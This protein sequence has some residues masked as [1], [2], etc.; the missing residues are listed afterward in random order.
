MAVRETA[1]IDQ[2]TGKATEWSSAE[3]KQTNQ[4]NNVPPTVEAPQTV[5]F[6][7][8]N[9]KRRQFLAQLAAG[10]GLG[11]VG[12]LAGTQ[13]D[14]R[15]SKTETAALQAPESPVPSTP[16]TER[17][18]EDRTKRLIFPSS[19]SEIIKIEGIAP[20]RVGA[21]N[22]ER[23]EVTIL[24]PEQ[25]GNITIETPVISGEPAT[26]KTDL[27]L[28]PSLLEKYHVT[29]D[30]VSSDIRD[31]QYGVN[32]P[33]ANDLVLNFI[34]KD[35]SIP[36]GS[37]TI[38]GHGVDKGGQFTCE[39]PHACDYPGIENVRFVDNKGIE[40]Q[41]IP[42]KDLPIA[43]RWNQALDSMVSTPNV[44]ASAKL[45]M[46]NGQQVNLYVNN[47]FRALS[48]AM[49]EKGVPAYTRSTGGRG[50]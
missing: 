40:I 46:N 41:S 31:R 42:V 8:E 27:V 22:K 33:T 49:G 7:V 39:S 13:T 44:D 38:K 15:R 45:D 21:H 43:E 9:P 19:K 32:N 25:M 11:G 17:I 35:G 36:N 18:I 16:A 14:C 47:R 10:A 50:R 12:F 30:S 1:T 2:K 23:H 24:S 3:Q 28:H 4:T 5:P 37:I 20:W 34:S 29:A 26:I 48:Q 6:P